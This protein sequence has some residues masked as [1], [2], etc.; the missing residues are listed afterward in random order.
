MLF[1]FIKDMLNCFSFFQ[2][3]YVKDHTK[4][5]EDLNFYK[6]KVGIVTALKDYNNKI[7]LS[8]HSKTQ[9]PPII[10]TVI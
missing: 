3:T 10:Q 2:S 9:T 7:T 6:L 4:R 5:L 8:H 1:K